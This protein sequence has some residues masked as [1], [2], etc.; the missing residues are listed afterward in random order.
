MSNNTVE[1]NAVGKIGAVALAGALNSHTG[2][3]IIDLQCAASASRMFDMCVT[4]NHTSC[5]WRL[6]CVPS[7]SIVA[8]FYIVLIAARADSGIL[9]EGAVALARTLQEQSA[10]LKLNLGGRCRCC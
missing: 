3:R 4:H 9:D 1:G 8:W 5:M 10:L 2:L 7:S 6:C